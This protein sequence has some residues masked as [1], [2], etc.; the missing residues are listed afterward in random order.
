M[1]FDFF[2]TIN[3]FELSSEKVLVYFS[4]WTNKNLEDFFSDLNHIK[5]GR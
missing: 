1:K 5:T 4:N 2:Y 3:E